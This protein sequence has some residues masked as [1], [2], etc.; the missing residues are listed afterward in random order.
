MEPETIRVHMVDLI[1]ALENGQE[2]FRSPWFGPQVEAA[3]ECFRTWEAW[4]IIKAK[5]EQQ[6]CGTEAYLGHK[7]AAHQ[8]DELLSKPTPK[9]TEREALIKQAAKYLNRVAEIDN[10]S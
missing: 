4:Q 3:Q 1:A 9:L 7:D 8:M 10:E 2:G 6:R 5:I